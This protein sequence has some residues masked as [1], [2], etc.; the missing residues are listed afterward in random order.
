MLY[1]ILACLFGGALWYG[2]A[3]LF[4]TLLATE[5]EDDLAQQ[6]LLLALQQEADA[7]V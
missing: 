5:H 2:V 1:A 4:E 7:S 6:E 3:W